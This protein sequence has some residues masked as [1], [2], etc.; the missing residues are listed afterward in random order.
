M[1]SEYSNKDFFSKQR[2]IEENRTRLKELYEQYKKTENYYP[3]FLAYITA[4][5]LYLFDFVAALLKY[6]CPW[7]FSSITILTGSAF[8]YVL[9]L[10]WKF[11]KSVDW[12]SDYLPHGVYEE[13]PAEIINE[14]PELENN[15][16]LFKDELYDRYIADL[17]EFV[18]KDLE[19]YRNKRSRLND[20]WKPMIISLIIY[21]VN[22]I[23]YKFISDNIKINEPQKIIIM[24][25]KKIVISESKHRISDNTQNKRSQRSQANDSQRKE[26][27]APKNN[28]SKK[29]NS[30]K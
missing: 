13:F 20:I 21:S 15:N 17:E 25:P 3:I 10:I 29:D 4:F 8:V 27:I 11:F 19:I 6:P 23:T 24:S 22:I 9:S 28:L 7:Y 30:T 5:G 14:K 12:H 16:E 18:E 2:R 1:T 26:Q